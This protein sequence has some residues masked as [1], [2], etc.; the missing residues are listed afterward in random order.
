MKKNSDVDR[1]LAIFYHPLFQQIITSWSGMFS[2]SSELQDL[3]INFIEFIEFNMKIQKCLLRDFNIENAFLS[4]LNDWMKEIL[5]CYSYQELYQ[6]NKQNQFDLRQE[7]SNSKFKLSL[8]E[9]DYLKFIELFSSHDAFRLMGFKLTPEVYT[10]SPSLVFH[11]RQ[12]V[13]RARI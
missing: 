12:S 13:I 8:E 9:K 11:L 7:I 3:K 1:S 5:E 2:G 10:H 6:N 4:A